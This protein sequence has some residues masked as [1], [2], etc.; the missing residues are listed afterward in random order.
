MVGE[1]QPQQAEAPLLRISRQQPIAKQ[2][3]ARVDLKRDILEIAIKGQQNL[4]LTQDELNRQGDKLKDSLGL[5]GKVATQTVVTTKAIDHLIEEAKVS[6]LTRIL[7]CCCDACYCCCNS[8]SNMGGKNKAAESGKDDEA[9]LKILAD[10]KL[11]AASKSPE[12][13]DDNDNQENIYNQTKVNK[14]I[15]EGPNNGDRS[16]KRTLEPFPSRLASYETDIW[17][18]QVDASLTQLQLMAEDMSQSLEEQTR[19]AN[20]LAIYLNFGLN[21]VTDANQNL[22]NQKALFL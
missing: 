11:K 5:A 19:L 2:Q 1:K 18:R 21:Q 22:N 20:M 3:P 9:R 8:R 15:S 17:Y 13:L 10:L 7:R 6:K 14:I 16:W 4:R 12:L